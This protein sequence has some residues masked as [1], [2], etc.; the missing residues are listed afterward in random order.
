[1]KLILKNLN[2]G[3]DSYAGFL[4]RRRQNRTIPQS[5]KSLP[6]IAADGKTDRTIHRHRYTTIYAGC[7][8]ADLTFMAKNI[9][10][11]NAMFVK[12][13]ALSERNYLV[14]GNIQNGFQIPAKVRVCDMA[15]VFSA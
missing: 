1:M 3:I 13:A 7:I 2:E 14:S 12:S 11:E 10:R 4:K 5:L 9:H 15:Q 6:L 8:S